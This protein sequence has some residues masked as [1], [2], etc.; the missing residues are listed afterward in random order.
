MDPSLKQQ[1]EIGE[2][3]RNDLAVW[4]LLGMATRAG[5]AVSGSEAVD[6]ALRKQQ[7]CLIMVAADSSSNT[8]SKYIPPGRP[9]AVPVLIYGSKEKMGHWTG[10]E[11]RAVTAILDQGF[12]KELTRLI[13]S[14][15]QWT[16]PLETK[17]E[18]IDL[19]EKVN[20]LW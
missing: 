6:N 18:E 19:E 9:P 16:D 1:Q 13:K 8:Q 10:H 5:R 12:A 4:R 11:E 14:S 17:S 2:T 15:G 20:I 3:A 7:A